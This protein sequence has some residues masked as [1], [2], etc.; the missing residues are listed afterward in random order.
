MTSSAEGDFGR[1]FTRKITL[2]AARF[3]E[4]GASLF[5]AGKQVYRAKIINVK[6]FDKDGN[7]MVARHRFNQNRNF[8]ENKDAIKAKLK[9]EGPMLQMRSMPMGCVALPAGT[10]EYEINGP[11]SVHYEEGVSPVDA[12]CGATFMHALFEVLEECDDAGVLDMF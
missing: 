12:L 9:E 1:F 4:T 5:R 6:L 2:R 7:R 10:N 11:G 8:K 3:N